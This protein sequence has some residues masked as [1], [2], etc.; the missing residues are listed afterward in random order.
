MVLPYKIDLFVNWKNCYTPA[1]LCCGQ[2][3]VL[4]SAAGREPFCPKKYI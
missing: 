1:K 2:I 3:A 4:V